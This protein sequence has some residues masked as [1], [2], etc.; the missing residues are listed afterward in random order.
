MPFHLYGEISLTLK[1]LRAVGG[2]GLPA[3][4]GGDLGTCIILTIAE[5]KTSRRDLYLQIYKR[6]LLKKTT[7][8]TEIWP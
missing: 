3:A 1:C 2:T 5:N 7:G 4:E 6:K 8:N